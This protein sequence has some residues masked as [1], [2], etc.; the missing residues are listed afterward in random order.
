TYFSTTALHRRSGTMIS[1]TDLDQLLA[2]YPALHELPSRLYR[3]LQLQTQ[4]IS[5]PAGR[6][7]FDVGDM[8]H[9]FLAIAAGSVRVV[10]PG[11]TG[12]EILLYRVQSGGTCILTISCLL[13]DIAYPA[14][15][16]V[17]R[18]LSGFTIPQ[19]LFLEMVNQSIAFRMYIFRLLADRIT[20]LM[21]LIEAIT[22]G[23]LE[24]RL[25]ALLLAKATPAVKTTHQILADELGS[26]RETV[27]RALEAFEQRGL[28]NL[29][30]G[31]ILILDKAALHDVAQ[32]IV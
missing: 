28:I 14:R 3:S 30:R 21:N 1:S 23:T 10:K 22:F 29:G 2:Y 7:L 13:G 26:T 12:Y 5:V 15:G 11:N 8:C 17:E 25:A 9:F 6:T 4:A 18:D 16:I 27:S 32:F 24:Q 31:Q 19:S 20:H